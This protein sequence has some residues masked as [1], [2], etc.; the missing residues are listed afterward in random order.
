MEREIGIDLSSPGVD[1]E[2]FTGLE[3]TID[4]FKQVGFDYVEI[5]VHSVD[6]IMNGRLNNEN[7]LRM[8]QILEYHGLKATVH[9][10]DLLNLREERNSDLQKQVFMASIDF[11]RIINANILV[12]HVGAAKPDSLEKWK[13]ETLCRKEIEALKSLCDYAFT[14]EVQICLENLEMTS[15][16]ELVDIITQ[17]QKENIGICYDFGHAYL[18]YNHFYEEGKEKF[19]E[20]VQTILPYLKHIHIH[21]NFGRVSAGPGEKPYIERLPFGEDDLHMPIGMGGIPYKKVFQLIR[22][23]KGIFLMEIKARYERFYKD[24][25]ETLKSLLKNEES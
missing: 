15:A 3:S 24:A 21:D 8:R 10:P 4:N 23:Y 5:A 14:R 13:T 22:G 12:Y 6:G 11:A 17:V 7:A 1:Q 20:S 16:Q 2:V 25:L 9:A 19:L 18:F